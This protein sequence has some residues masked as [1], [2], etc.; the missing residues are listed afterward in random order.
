MKNI[1]KLSF[2]FVL[3]FAVQTFPSKQAEMN[4]NMCY[5]ENANQL[6]CKQV[7]KQI[8]LIAAIYAIIVPATVYAVGGF[9]R[10]MLIVFL[11]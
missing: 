8:G 7:A 10:L 11:I 9:Y 3:L 5:V 1:T 2:F 6:S 4:E